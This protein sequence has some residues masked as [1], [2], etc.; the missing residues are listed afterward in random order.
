MLSKQVFLRAGTFFKFENR[1]CKCSAQKYQHFRIINWFCSHLQDRVWSACKI[2]LTNFCFHKR[3]L[4]SVSF[5]SPQ[6]ISLRSYTIRKMTYFANACRFSVYLKYS[7]IDFRMH[8]PQFETFSNDYS[9]C[10]PYCHIGQSLK[11]K[12]T[13]NINNKKD[14][15]TF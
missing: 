4:T 2:K 13:E 12:Q 7:F 5:N 3:R 11:T 9:R 6:N 1:I 15:G 10:V 8:S 14:G